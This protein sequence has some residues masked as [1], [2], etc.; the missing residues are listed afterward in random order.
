MQSISAAAPVL[1]KTALSILV[2]H[3]VIPTPGNA[4]KHTKCERK[5]LKSTK[6]FCDETD[7]KQHFRATRWR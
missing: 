7:K 2:S 1:R 3:T 6:R 4:P 5:R